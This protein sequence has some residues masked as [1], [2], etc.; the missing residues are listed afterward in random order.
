MRR[1]FGLAGLLVLLVGAGAGLYWRAHRMPDAST[2]QVNAVPK[3][4]LY[5]DFYNFMHSS[6]V[7]SFYFAVDPGAGDGPKYTELYVVENEGQKTD[8]GGPDQ[9]PSPQWSYAVDEDG[10]PTIASPDGATRIVLYGLKP[11]IGGVFWIEAGVRSDSY[12]NL[13]GK[14]RQAHYAS[15][16]ANMTA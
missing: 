6:T 9:P 4:T 8:F 13:E 5:C 14:C 16:S 12:R 2:Q 3:P 1:A 11:K 15:R 7:A 10:T